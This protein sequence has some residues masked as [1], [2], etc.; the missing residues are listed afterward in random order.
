MLTLLHGLKTAPA[1]KLKA[2]FIMTFYNV[3]SF[4]RDETNDKK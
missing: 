2:N 1:L 3:L 4:G